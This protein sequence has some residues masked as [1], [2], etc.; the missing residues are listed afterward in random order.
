MDGKTLASTNVTGAGSSTGLRGSPKPTGLY[1]QG[2]A[3]AV[4]QVQAPP[5]PSHMPAEMSPPTSRPK[6]SFS[7]ICATCNPLGP[8]TTRG[9]V[10]PMPVDVSAVTMPMEAEAIAVSEKAPRQ[11]SGA[12]AA[13]FGP[14]DR[15]ELR[16]LVGAIII[17]L[18]GSETLVRT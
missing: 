8:G 17:T 5:S 12:G 2:W 4:A 6:M 15:R 14:S 18:L 1:V 7:M 13:A 10:T 3:G 9:V 16:L 11:M